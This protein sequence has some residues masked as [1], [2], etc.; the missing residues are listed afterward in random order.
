[1]SEKIKFFYYNLV[2]QSATVITP[3]TENAQYPASNLKHDFRTKIFR[4]TASSANIVFDFITAE[5]VDSIIVVDNPLNGFG[6]NGALTIEANATDSWGSPAFS[7]TLTPS[8][9]FGFGLK[10]LT[11]AQSYRYWRISGTGAS[12]FE[13]SKIFIGKAFSPQR[14]IG[15][16]FTY[17]EDDQSRFT[18]SDYGQRFVDVLPSQK[19]IRGNINLINKANVDD[20][21]DFINYVGRNK[22]FFC[23]L[24]ES[25]EI[26]N[27][28]ERLSG[29]FYF[30]DRPSAK[31]VIHGIYSFTV[32]MEGAL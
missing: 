8:T 2:N 3:S 13:L 7:T 18:Q 22:P 14:N 15:T 19:K 17:E 24:N 29:M 25:E 12:Y 6:F 23:V 16:G 4:S 26:I 10:T 32:T 31:H 30:R 28:F 20:F 1:M 11:A 27:D 9:E 21:F 5:E